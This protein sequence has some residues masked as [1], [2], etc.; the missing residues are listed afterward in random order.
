MVLQY[1]YTHSSFTKQTFL[2]EF[3]RAKFARK[4]AYL[5]EKY[6]IILGYNAITS[7]IIKKAN[8]Y[9]LRAVVIEKEEEKETIF[10]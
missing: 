3:E 6:I 8:E 2:E 5:K 9:G 10:F 7:E 4:V 1:R